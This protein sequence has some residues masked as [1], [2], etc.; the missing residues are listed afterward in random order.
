MSDCKLIRIG[1]ASLLCF[2]IIAAPLNAANWLIMSPG[3][4][5]QF[6]SNATI[7]GSGYVDTPGQSAEFNF[8]YVDNGLTVI[9]GVADVFGES[10]MGWNIWNCIL[11]PPQNGW[12]LSPVNGMAPRTP[13]HWTNLC[14]VGAGA[15]YVATGPH[16]VVP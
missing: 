2:I 4:A 9:E 10:W 14:A 11:Y 3:A 7:N 12:Q 16:R 15:Q 8:Y 1:A 13:D 6:G 5:A